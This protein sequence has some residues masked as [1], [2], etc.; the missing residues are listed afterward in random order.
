MGGG[1]PTI[2]LVVYS[3]H[4]G[5]E[6]DDDDDDKPSP[7]QPLLQFDPRDSFSSAAEAAAGAAAANQF[8][9]QHQYYVK[10]GVGLYSV[11]RRPETSSPQNGNGW[12]HFP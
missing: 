9:E 12:L 7:G 3:L 2:Q 11:S 4:C 6:H 5:A 1:T 10:V 8:L